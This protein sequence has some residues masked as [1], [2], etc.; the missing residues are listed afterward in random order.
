MSQVVTQRQK[1]ISLKIK[2]LQVGVLAYRG[3]DKALQM[4]EPT[5]QYLSHQL[6]EYT[7]KF[8]LLSF[9]QIYI[10]AATNKLDFVIADSSVYVELESL[11]QLN[12]LAT[13]KN[14]RMGKAYT[15]FGGVIFRR[16]DRQD[17]QNLQDL[18]GK[19]FA[20]TNEHSLGAWQ[21]AWREIKAAGI[22][23]YRDFLSLQFMGTHDAVVYAVR[24]GLV[25]A[26]TVR[27]DALEKMAAEGK[28]NL[29]EF[30][31]INQQTQ[32]AREFPFALST[33]LYPEWAFA[34][35]RQVEQNLAERVAIALLQI[36]QLDPNTALAAHSQGWTVPL[37][38]EP[39]HECHKELNLGAYA[40]KNRIN[41]DLAI[42]GSDDGLW[43]WNIETNEMFFSERWKQ[44]LGYTD[45]EITNHRQQW[46][47]L[48]HRDDLA[49]VRAHTHNYLQ[50]NI[51]EY[52]SEHRLQHRDGSYR[53]ILTRGVVLRDVH[54]TPY[55]MAGSSSDITKRKLAESA[56]RESESMLKEG[57]LELKNT[58]RKLQQT[59][60]QLIQTEKMSSL[61]QLV[62][63]IAH[64]INNPVNFIHG[65]VSYAFDYITNI[66]DLLSLYRHHYSQPHLEIEQKTE[67]FD[68]EFILTDLP[69]LLKSMQ[70]GTDRITKIV[71]SLRNFSRL[72]E[73]ERKPIDIH[74][75]LEN[76]VLILQ[77]NLKGKT[78]DLNVEIIKEYGDLPL[79]ECYAGQLNQVFMNILSNAIDAFPKDL[80]SPK[81]WIKTELVSDR[82]VIAIADNGSGITPEVQKH[83]FD[84]FFT[85][86]PVGQGTGLG[87]A[88]SYQII[89][90]KHK[91]TLQCFS[92]LGKGTEFRIEI[93]LVQ[94][95]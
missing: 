64:E 55:R 87:L 38:Y 31:I 78:G 57:T 72:D 3:I 33:R 62:A 4:W 52:A 36:S 50:G 41:F 2:I 44:M 71:Q 65:N 7:F 29:E 61:G 66:I 60:A 12:R 79:V 58:L 74:E 48:I 85:T 67:E 92:E 21:S 27:T 95:G 73:A 24:D 10:E 59:Q 80:A 34:A 28:I 8:L 26:G 32:Y 77:Y 90:E 47:Q 49:Q 40:D 83:L 46:E 22:D 93:P 56:L 37:N 91:G 23:P 84:P 76:T 19:K 16:S 42:K 82:V 70:V 1:Q 89:V 5:S 94:G 25:D 17:I 51:S 14:L 86:K 11:Y 39:V 43:D 15:V 35:S 9:E 30:E 68:L 18:V 13:L 45:Y 69:K 54:G 63:G 53:W 6:P 88:I 81:I 75:G 20:G